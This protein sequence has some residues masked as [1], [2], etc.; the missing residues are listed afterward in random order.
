MGQ[1]IGEEEVYLNRRPGHAQL[2]RLVA[3]TFLA[4]MVVAGCRDPTEPRAPRFN[5]DAERVADSFVREALSGD[6]QEAAR[7]VNPIDV[8]FVQDLTEGLTEYSLRLAGPKTITGNKVRY[9]L[10]G[11][12]FRAETVGGGRGRVKAR[13]DVWM[14][15]LSPEWLVERWSFHVRSIDFPPAD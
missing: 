12:A 2:V 6:W 3:A 14:M 15:F 13:L 4:G 10:R 7:F 8:Q 9:P 11:T 5:E 1:P